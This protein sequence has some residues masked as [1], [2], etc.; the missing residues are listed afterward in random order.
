MAAF[1]F[2]IVMAEQA[3]AGPCA[4]VTME[5]M[6][7]SAS[8][9]KCG[10]S[11]YCNPSTPPKIYLK[12]TY[13]ETKWHHFI[14]DSDWIGP[15]SIPGTAEMKVISVY[16]RFTCDP[17]STFSGSAS[18]TVIVDEDYDLN[19]F[20]D[21]I[22]NSATG[23]WTDSFSPSGEFDGNWF[24][25]F[26]LASYPVYADA[27]DEVCWNSGRPDEINGQ[28]TDQVF[29]YTSDDPHPTFLYSESSASGSW[30]DEE[31]FPY[32]ES[33]YGDYYLKNTWTLE[34][35][36]TDGMLRQDMMSL[37]PAYPTDWSA[38]SGSAFYN[39]TSDHLSCSGGKM[40][41]RVHVTDCVPRENYLVTWWEITVS[42]PAGIVSSISKKTET[43]TG[44]DDPVNGVE[45]QVH[46][47]D[48]PSNPSSIYETTPTVKVIQSSQ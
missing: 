34:D 5:N 43:L 48:V 36:Y 4:N 18:C 35:E 44:S 9:D 31:D 3:Q 12:Q 7:T 17:T 11:E 16:D 41:Y 14:Y 26:Y 1:V 24:E 38:G 2:V 29:I 25:S 20:S 21:S 15:L 33:W 46:E 45:G 19:T 23:E 40:K 10:F 32:H 27:F 39:M 42:L 30:D 13:A 47:V 28:S 6:S 8:K 22:I 37:I